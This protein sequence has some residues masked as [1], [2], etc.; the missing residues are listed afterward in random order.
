MHRG[1]RHRLGGL[2]VPQDERTPAVAVRLRAGEHGDGVL[3]YHEHSTRAVWQESVYVLCYRVLISM[4]R[5]RDFFKSFS[6]ALSRGSFSFDFAL[7][8]CTCASLRHAPFPS[9]RPS[10]P[11]P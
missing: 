9:P 11:R 10:S 1:R 5:N 2:G 4:T 3:V 6:L 8:Q 7:F